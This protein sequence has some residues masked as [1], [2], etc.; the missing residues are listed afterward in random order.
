MKNSMLARII[1]YNNLA[2]LLERH[3]LR[4]IERVL[5]PDCMRSYNDFSLERDRGTL[6]VELRK[7]AEEKLEKLFDKLDELEAV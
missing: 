6:W 3:T 1:T 5:D 4:E 2:E 7:L